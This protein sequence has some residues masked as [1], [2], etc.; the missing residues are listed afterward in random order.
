MTRK[1]LKTL[2][3]INQIYSEPCQ[4]LFSVSYTSLMRTVS[5]A[6][7]SPFLPILFVIDFNLA[8]VSAF[9][10]ATIS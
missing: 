1:E 3:E 2:G 4:P 5:L 7:I 6:V 10:F 9:M 8:T